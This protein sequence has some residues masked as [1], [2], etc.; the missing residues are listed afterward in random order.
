M[1][2]LSRRQCRRW[3]RRE[4]GGRRPIV[5]GFFLCLCFCLVGTIVISDGAREHVVCAELGRGTTAG[6]GGVGLVVRDT[7]YLDSLSTAVVLEFSPVP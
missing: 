7:P 1:S 4:A 2:L 5:R 3:G 6:A